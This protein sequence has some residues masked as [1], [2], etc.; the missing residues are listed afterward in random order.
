VII[1]VLLA[2]A[3]VVAAPVLAVVVGRMINRRNKPHLTEAASSP[4]SWEG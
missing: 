3:Y 2:V 1:I 4:A